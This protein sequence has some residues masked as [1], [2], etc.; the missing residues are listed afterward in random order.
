[1]QGSER[2]AMSYRSDLSAPQ[3]ALLE[4]LGL[5]GRHDRA[6]NRTVLPQHPA[7]RKNVGYELQDWV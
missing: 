3:M 5:W 6:A 7:V 2:N 1:L 4:D